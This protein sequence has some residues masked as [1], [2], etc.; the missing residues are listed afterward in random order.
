MEY[1]QI[2]ELV[3]NNDSIEGL[4]SAFQDA[5]FVLNKQEAINEA[6]ARSKAEGVDEG[7]KEGG[8]KYALLD[9]DLDKSGV[10][11]KELGVNTVEG[12]IK[13]IVSQSASQAKTIE[14]LQ[15]GNDSAVNTLQ[16]ELD[17]ARKALQ[18]KDSEIQAIQ[19]GFKTK[20]QEWQQQDIERRHRAYVDNALTKHFAPEHHSLL[21]VSMMSDMA[22]TVAEGD[23]FAYSE[24]GKVAFRK[25]GIDAKLIDSVW[26]DKHKAYVRHE[27]PAGPGSNGNNGH[28]GPGASA[29]DWQLPS[30]SYTEQTKAIFEA[31]QQFKWT[32][33]EI[34][35]K[36]AERKR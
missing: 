2:K 6:L 13:H 30:G 26:M 29:K 22:N 35:E 20:Q 19:D 8:G 15:S 11:W 31:A 18:G 14:A 16:L 27:T 3:E 17:Q 12:K 4:T 32:S 5:G 34:A 10:D 33:N 21:R 7:R 25:N 36:L 23:R 28:S 24:D 1:A 9:D